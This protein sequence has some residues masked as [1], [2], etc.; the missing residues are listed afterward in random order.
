MRVILS[1]CHIGGV[2]WYCWW[3]NYRWNEDISE[4]AK[5]GNGLYIKYGIYVMWVGGNN[6]GKI[7]N[8][9]FIYSFRYIY[10]NDSICALTSPSR[11]YIPILMFTIGIMYTTHISM[12]AFESYKWFVGFGDENGALY[13]LWQIVRLYSSVVLLFIHHRL[14][15]FSVYIEQNGIELIGNWIDSSDK[16]NELKYGKCWMR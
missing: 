6:R 13:V 8:Y 15:R 9:D 16:K 10:L 12:M 14:A 4:G 3:L 11:S 7:K 2:V 1:F 5:N